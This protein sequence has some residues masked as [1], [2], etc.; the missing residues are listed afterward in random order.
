[1][2]PAGALATLGSQTILMTRPEL[3]LLP[4]TNVPPEPVPL[5]VPPLP[6]ALTATLPRPPAS[7]SVVVLTKARLALMRR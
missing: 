7:V 3:P 2:N 1:M 4:E 6:A 5:P